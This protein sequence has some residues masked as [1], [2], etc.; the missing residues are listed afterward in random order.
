MDERLKILQMVREGKVTPE[1]AVELLNAIQDGN[2]D[3]TIVESFVGI[4]DD[5]GGLPRRLR[6]ASVS[7]KGSKTVFDIPLGVLKFIYSLFPNS[8]N[9]NINHNQLD[10]K[11][12]MDM[13]YSGDKGIIYRED[14]VNG[15]GVVIELV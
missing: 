1:Q 10:T 5:K 9:F 6:I 3:S 8:I 2:G 14:S 13:V 7:S 15:S 11:Q 12:I 4:L